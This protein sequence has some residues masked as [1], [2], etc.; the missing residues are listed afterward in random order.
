M[1]DTTTLQRRPGTNSLRVVPTGWTAPEGTHVFVLG[2]DE[3]GY[4]GR[5]Q[6]GDYVSVDQDGGWGDSFHV[7]V[8]ARLRGPT[9][10]PTPTDDWKWSAIGRIGSEVAWA[11]DLKQPR[12]VDDLIDL[13]FNVTGYVP[14]QNFKV[15][16]QLVGPGP[17]N[18][19]EA[20][21]PAVYLDEWTFDPTDGLFL[22]NRSPQPGETG[23]NRDLD[24]NLD[25]SD[26][27]SDIDETNTQIYVQGVLAYDGAAGGAQPGFDVSPIAHPVLAGVSRWRIKR[28]LHDL[29]PSETVVEVR[30]VSRNL[31]GTHVLDETY[32][33]TTADETAPVVI[34]AQSR[35]HKVVRVVF[36]EPVDDSA[37]E[38]TRYVFERREGPSVAVTAVSVDRVTS[39]V[40]DVNL[41]VTITRALLYR[42][43][44]TGVLDVLGNEILEPGSS[45]DFRGYECAFPVERDFEFW[46]MLSRIARD[47][48]DDDTLFRTASVVQEI[49]DT[50]LC[51]IDRWTDIVDVDV[52]AERYVDHMLIGLGNPFDFDL[53]LEDKRRLVRTL[54]RIYQRK[55]TTLGIID[56]VR[57][58]LG[59][60]VTIDEWNTSTGWILGDS[61]LGVDTILGPSD[62]RALYTFDVVSVVTLTDE[63]RDRIRELVDYMKP[64]HTHLGS[65]IEPTPPDV[66]DHVELGLSELGGDEFMLH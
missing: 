58:F 50:L 1:A 40:V 13:A 22:T 32:S 30:V 64:A 47:E 10:V 48:D 60:E 3:P 25:V 55:G 7:R 44:V 15:Y 39:S 41:D 29:Y 27:A 65:I 49:I 54:V 23:V 21:I 4:T 14:P 35:D 26:T 62:Q 51:E 11:I 20:E 8:K 19:A 42:L 63:Q 57:F 34:Q 52:A 33:Y 28:T 12:H 31:L 16:L 2:S 37:L 17:G 5:F 38:P 6:S 46:K 24:V 43:T 36:D 61:E 9:T 59:L 18:Y 66:I 45:V 53:D 56:V